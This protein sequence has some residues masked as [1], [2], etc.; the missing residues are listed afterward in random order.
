M[1]LSDW[2][3]WDVLGTCPH[4]A[5]AIRFMLSS[6]DDWGPINIIIASPPTKPQTW[7]CPHCRVKTTQTFDGYVGHVRRVG[8][9]KPV[10]PDALKG[11]H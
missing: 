8:P 11:G 1:T 5:G 4:C 7:T 10:N 3:R 9:K 2:R 6:V